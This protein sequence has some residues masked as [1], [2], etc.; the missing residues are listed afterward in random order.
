M[1]V[2]PGLSNWLANLNAA[3]NIHYSSQNKVIF[4]NEELFQSAIFSAIYHERVAETSEQN[5]LIYTIVKIKAEKHT[6]S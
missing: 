2:N 1:N 6:Q 5:A 3:D 4:S